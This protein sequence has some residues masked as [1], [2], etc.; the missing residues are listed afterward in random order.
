MS[1]ESTRWIVETIIATVGVF[2]AVLALLQANEA[3]D[4]ST[5]Q[6]QLAT[7]PYVVVEYVASDVPIECQN[8]KLY[9]GYVI[10]NHGNGTAI[11]GDIEFRSADGQR[12]HSLREL[13]DNRDE[14]F[15]AAGVPAVPS[16][17]EY[18]EHFYL[19]KGSPLSV[20]GCVVL[21]G[22]GV[23]LFTDEAD[24]QEFIDGLEKLVPKL[25]YESISGVACTLD[26]VKKERECTFRGEQWP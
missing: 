9:A 25:S 8:R 15:A 5:D 21:A 20:N 7:H 14:I 1:R 13:I 18:W 19:G 26:K 12:W 2:V 23:D 22:L 3:L 6:A 17:A 24:P 16:P 4:A 11:I 10:R